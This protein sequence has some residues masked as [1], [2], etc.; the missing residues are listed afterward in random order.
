M[1]IYGNKGL[2]E[3]PRGPVELGEDDGVGRGERQ[4]HPRSG[5]AEQ[6]DLTCRIFLK[7]IT[8]ALGDGPMTI[9]YYHIW[10]AF[11]K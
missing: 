1:S 10:T 11:L 4:A 5:D 3:I 6:G 2:G 9:N 7:F 8:E